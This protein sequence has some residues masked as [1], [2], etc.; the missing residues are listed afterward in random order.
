MKRNLFGLVM[1]ILVALALALTATAQEKKKAAKE[2]RLSG[3]IQM[4]NKDSSTITLQRGNVKRT[5][6]YST[7]TTVTYLNKPAGMEELKEGRRAIVL[8][9]FNEKGQ[10]M[11][12]R[13]ELRN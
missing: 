5:V 3:T 7:N 1:G 9:K 4:L 13:I 10:L 11:A 6:I 12:T 8:G 2:D